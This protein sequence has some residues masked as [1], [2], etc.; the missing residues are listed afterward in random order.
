MA[1]WL[2]LGRVAVVAAILSVSTACR[3][4]Q[5]PVASTP[6]T[7]TP[8]AIDSEQALSDTPGDPEWSAWLQQVRRVV[9][10]GADA[11]RACAQVA[12]AEQFKCTCAKACR[13]QFPPLPHGT[14]FTS[15]EW[16][17]LI[18]LQ[19]NA[20]GTVDACRDPRTTTDCPRP[21]P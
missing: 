6:A 10:T 11:R 14:R 1:G 21:G 18:A 17:P 2:D 15:V 8:P 4:P 16:P 9:A 3:H 5:A 12:G 7:D 13:L 19:V 20:N